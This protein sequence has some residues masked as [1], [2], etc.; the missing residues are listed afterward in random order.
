M[1]TKKVPHLFLFTL[2]VLYGLMPA[3]YAIHLSRSPVN[4]DIH[5]MRYRH[6]VESRKWNDESEESGKRPTFVE[7]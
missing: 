7:V 5:I 4:L 3:L 1:M 2:P 6:D